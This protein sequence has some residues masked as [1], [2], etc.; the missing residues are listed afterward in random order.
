MGD[1]TYAVKVR[2]DVRD[3]YGQLAAISRQLDVGG[4]ASERVHMLLQTLAA[5]EENA[6]KLAEVRHG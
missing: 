3:T 4:D 2:R 1:E 5:I 6:E